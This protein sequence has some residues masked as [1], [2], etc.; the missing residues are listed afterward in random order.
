MIRLFELIGLLAAATAV[1]LVLHLGGWFATSR[2]ILLVK[3]SQPMSNISHLV[4]AK[5]VRS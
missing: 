2:A 5:E 1:T 4:V 3:C